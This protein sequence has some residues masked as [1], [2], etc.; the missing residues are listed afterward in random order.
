MQCRKQKNIIYNIILN[1]ALIH[2]FRQLTRTMTGNGQMDC[3]NGLGTEI[4]IGTQ[5]QG[6]GVYIKLSKMYQNRK[7]SPR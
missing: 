6:T 2:K 7:F 1:V 5:G 3:K 4:P